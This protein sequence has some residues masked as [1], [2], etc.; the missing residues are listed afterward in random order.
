[1][2]VPQFLVLFVFRPNVDDNGVNPLSN[3]ALDALQSQ[4]QE[5]VAVLQESRKAK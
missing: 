5:T 1:M 3:Q 4:L 2:H